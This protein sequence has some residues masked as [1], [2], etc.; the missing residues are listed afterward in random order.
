[1]TEDTSTHRAGPARG[2][3]YRPAI[4][5]LRA[6][7]VVGVIVFHLVPGALPGGWFG[8]DV[9]FVISGFLITALLLSEHRLSRGHINLMSFWRARA[10]RLIPALLPVLIAVLVAATFLSPTGRRGAIAGDVL[11]TLG[12]VAN[13]RFVLGDEAYFGQ[14][15][16]PSPVRHAWSLAVEE[17]FY[18][19]YPLLLIVLLSLLRRRLTLVV[20]LTSIGLASAGLMVLLH[21]PGLDPSRVYYGTDTRAHQ[22][23]VGAV[24]AATLSPGPGAISRPIARRLDLWC[25]R[26]SSPALI[27]VVSALWWASS[28]QEQLFEGAIVPLSVAVGI[29]IVA[30][31]SSRRTVTQRVLGWEPLRRVGLVSYGLYLWHWPIVVFLNAEVLPW[32][33]AARVVVQLSLTVLLALLSFRFIERPVRQRGVHALIPRLPRAGAVVAWASVPLIIAG[34]LTMPVAARN[35]AP[36]SL[37]ADGEIV[38]PEE[39]YVPKSST[40]TAALVGNSVPGTLVRDFPGQSHPDLRLIDETNPG[41]DTL[42]AAKYFD[43]SRQPELA[44]CEAW[45]DGLAEEI[46]RDSPDVVLY[47]IPQSWVTDRWVSAEVIGFG[48]PRWVSLVEGALDDA[49][50]A[51]RGSNLALVNLACHSM[52]SYGN[53]ELERINDTVLVRE[54]NET[55]SSWASTNDVPVLD[56]YS[57]LCPDNQVVDL[58]NGVPLYEDWMHFTPESGPIFWRWLAPRVQSVARGEDPS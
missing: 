40:V 22:L 3:T 55:V 28:A 4:D 1:M 17:Q 32:P 53:E 20:C 49:L 21:E 26:L 25:R 14:I 24:L 31:S 2:L 30:A 38:V 47:F 56:S 43:G 50:R 13:W 45:R 42:G 52:P 19:F 54:I 36:A 44:E 15:A 48:S 5:G 11:A 18:I 9:F 37:T 7:S 51:S 35:I 41:C 57:L 23:I 34:A 58:I 16:S 27:V 6:I 12:Y 39:D 46:Q 10:R 29:V 8:V 33:T